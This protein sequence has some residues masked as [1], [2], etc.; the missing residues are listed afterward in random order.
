MKTRTCFV[1]NS[2]SSSYVC[3]VCGETYEG[4][5]AS[6]Y[7]SNMYEC[8]RGHI[9]CEDHIDEVE[10]EAWKESEI[11]KNMKEY[12]LSHDEAEDELEDSDYRYEFPSSVCPCCT[13][14]TIVD[15]DLIAYLLHISNMTR[16]ECEDSIREKFK[17]S[18][19]LNDICK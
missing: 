5:D 12:E 11:Q 7:D 14:K 16:L 17:S 8:K 6:L 13:L 2:S 19:E 18:K 15:S 3:D 10:F 1:S 4:Y 9:F